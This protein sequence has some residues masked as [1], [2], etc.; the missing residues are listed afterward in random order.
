MNAGSAIGG[1]MPSEPALAPIPDSIWNAWRADFPHQAAF[2]NARSALAAL[3]AGCQIRRVWLPAYVCGVLAEAAAAAQVAARYYD[4]SLQLEPDGAALQHEL[5]PGDA[6]VI[7]A[8]FG[9]PPHD[10]WRDLIAH[11]PEVLFIEDR[12]QAL[13]TGEASLAGAVIYSP[14]KLLGVADGGLLFARGPL[15][16]P[17]GLADDQL[18]APQD[19]RAAD[20]DGRTPEHWRPLFIAAEDSMQTSRAPATARTLAALRS[21]GMGPIARAR[22]ANWR[23]L[24]EALAPWA[25]WRETAPAFAPLAFPILTADAA[26]A[27]AA[28]AERRIW[29]PRHWAS[30]PSDA[31]AFPDAH[32]LAGACVSL[33]LDQRCGAAE[34]SRIIETVA[35][36]VPRYRR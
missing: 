22:R 35:A 24:A 33:P 16:D 29:A 1:V 30:L 23:L 4:I 9:R 19:A 36:C 12:A 6:V 3:L 2:A 18:W 28:L 34:M 32:R 7:V 11:R 5:A 21:T 20:L 15:P 8:Y 13:D 14:R 27:V 31:A 26:G 25:L 10:A 17:A